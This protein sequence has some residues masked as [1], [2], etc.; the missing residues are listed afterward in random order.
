MKGFNLRL[1]IAVIAI[2]TIVNGTYLL[3]A[4][5]K[6]VDAYREVPASEQDAVLQKMSDNLQ[7]IKTLR[8]G[9]VQERH[10]S[11]FLD[12]LS[13]RGTL[14]FE[15]PDRLRWE[16]TEPYTSVLLFNGGYVAK[17]NLE[18]GRLQKMKLGMEDLLQEVLKQI[19]SIMSGDFKKVRDVYTISLIHGKDYKVIMK[20]VSAGMAKVIKSLELSID[21]ASNHVTKIT[22]REPQGDYIEIRFS[23]EEE[24]VSFDK[25][26]FDLNNPLPPKGLGSAGNR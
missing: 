11:M 8:A 16:L 10:L 21:Q 4:G 9:F 26:L 20:P 18:N 17:F 12:V 3:F 5:E 1:Y 22:I 13:A 15:I 24:N 14:Y 25:R 7:S 19:I 6:G 2:L 23:G